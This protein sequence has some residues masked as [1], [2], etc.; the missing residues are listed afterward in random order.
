MLFTEEALS[1]KYIE[2]RAVFAWFLD[3]ACRI[4][5]VARSM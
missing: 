4:S 3:A 2:D 1:A 5:M